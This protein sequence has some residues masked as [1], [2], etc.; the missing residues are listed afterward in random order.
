MK[1]AACAALSFFSFDQ[2]SWSRKLFSLSQREGCRSFL[3]ALASICRMRSGVTSNWLPTSSI[4]WSVDISM[5][6]RMRSTLASRGVSVSSTSFV[7]SRRLAKVAASE[8]ASVDW[9]SMKSPRCESS[10]SPIGVSIEI[11]SLEILRI[12]RIFS[13]GISMRAARVAGSG[14]W[15]VS[16]RIWRLRRVILLMVS[17]MCPGMGMVRASSAIERVIACRID[18]VDVVDQLAP[19]AFGASEDLDEVLARHLGLLDADVVDRALVA[20]DLIDQAPHAVGEPLDGARGEADPHQLVGDLVARAQEVLVLRARVLQ[21]LRH[22]VVEAANARELLQ[23][24][25][26]HVQQ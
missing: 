12:L 19:R 15:P 1:R 6:K 4:V 14:S 9:S 8:G 2:P 20:A 16:C 13:S 22:L 25:A 23:R 24:L 11:G 18:H 26:A 3:S 10:S 7:T 21:R 17:I 5:P